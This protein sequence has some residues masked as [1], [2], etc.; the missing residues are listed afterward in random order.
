MTVKYS[1]ICGSCRQKVHAHVFINVAK[2]VANIPSGPVLGCIRSC[3]VYFKTI[4]YIKLILILS[5]SMT[6]VLLRNRPLI[7]VWLQIFYWMFQM[8]SVSGGKPPS[9]PD[10]G[11]CPMGD[12]PQNANYKKLSYRRGTAQCQ[13]TSCQLPRNSAESTCTTSPEIE[14]MK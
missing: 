4:C 8:S 11:L 2:I 13:L 7:H 6:I 1:V 14:V 12:S 3:C 9:P 10:Q 5:R